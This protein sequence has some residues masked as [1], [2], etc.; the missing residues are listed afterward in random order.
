MPLTRPDNNVPI[1]ALLKRFA[2]IYLPIVL[3]FSIGLLSSVRLDEQRRAEITEV[4]ETSRIE[5]AKRQ[6]TQDLAAAKIDLRVFANL[7]LLRWF[8]DSG[9]P[10]QREELEK[11]FLVVMRESRHYDQMRYL[12]A[13][14]QEL[15]RINYN[16]GKPAIVPREQLQNKLGRY[17]FD[18]TLELNQ[19]EIFVSP[20]DLNIEQSS[21]EI[22]HK[23]IIRFGTPV[24]D[25]A[26][27]KQGVIVLNYF[28]D[29]LLQHFRETMR[30]GDPHSGMLLNRDGY[31]LSSPKREDEW[32]F[33]LGKKAGTFGHDF[34]DEW[35]AIS[36][37]EQGTLRTDRGI[38]VYTTVYPLSGKERSSTG[39]TLAHAPSQQELAAHEYHW[40]I[41]SFVPTAVLSGAAFYNQTGSWI[42]LAFI[43]LLLALAAWVIAA[44]TLSRRQVRDELERQARIDLLTGLNNRR[45]FFELAK[46]E[47]ERAKRHGAPLP[48][49]MLDV[50]HFKLVNDTYG[51][52]VGDLVLQKLS[53]VCVQTLR[54]IDILG[55]FGGEEFAILLP[56]TKIEQA[57]EVAERLRL[58]VAGATVPLEQG[59][60]IHITVSIGVASLVATDARVE[61]MLKRADAALYAAKN[62][63]RNR[64]C[65]EGTG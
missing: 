26:G 63:G 10:V 36:A 29:E 62:T 8:Q 7:P 55:R 53:E 27:H 21:L 45:H 11:L 48:A 65:S 31:W 43:Y 46:K 50:D 56:E 42:L 3:V 61:D 59:G 64:V 37:T 9:N 24:F 25:S 35:R 5:I 13:S 41:V 47:L 52:H 51:H 32:G 16:N 1:Q 20:L 4:R 2:L 60:S 6:I 34:S 18:D 12:D 23:P 30:G 57:L 28:G 19:G 40:K 39:S 44:V 38:F 17:Y 22:P 54:G 58:A 33:M 15:I 49:L 14:G